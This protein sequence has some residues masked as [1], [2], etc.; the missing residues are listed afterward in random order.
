V[1]PGRALKKQHGDW[2]LAVGCR[3]KPNERMQGNGGSRKKLATACRVITC[4]AIP[5]RCKE[6]G[7]DKAVPRTQKGQTFG[8]RHQAK[9]EG[10]RG[11]RD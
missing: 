4:R 8:M 7:K 6:Q 5:A 11:I 1:K 10:V 9:P 2:N 3:R